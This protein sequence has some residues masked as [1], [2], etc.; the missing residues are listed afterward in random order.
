MSQKLHQLVKPFVGTSAGSL[1]VEKAISPSSSVDAQQVP[2][3]F[4]GTSVALQSNKST[5]C[6]PK[7]FA[8][9][10]GAGAADYKDGTPYRLTFMSLPVPGHPVAVRIDYT[11]GTGVAQT[12]TTTL[13][14]GSALL[15]QLLV[16]TS[17]SATTYRITAKSV[18]L[19]MDANA[20]TNNGTIYAVDVDNSYARTSE[21]LTSGVTGS[22]Y[23]S[24][25]WRGQTLPNMSP[26]SISAKSGSVAWRAV[27]GIYAVSRNEGE[28]VWARANNANV[29]SPANSG[30]AG[31]LTTAWEPALD[32][33]VPVI[34]VDNLNQNASV[35]C[36][37]IT[38]YEIQPEIGS[39]IQDVASVS[40]V[41]MAALAVYKSACA[42]F[43]AFYPADFNDWGTLW[44]GIKDF[45]AK[46]KPYIA[47]AANFIPGVGPLISTFIDGIPAQTKESRQAAMKQQRDKA[48]RA[49]LIEAAALKNAERVLAVGK[50]QGGPKRK[51][52]VPAGKA[53]RS[54]VVTN[55]RNRSSSTN[56]FR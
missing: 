23:A 17:T 18:T 11:G 42:N 14:E 29:Q 41:D 36:K 39:I 40:A 54:M 10:V 45:F 26:D 51:S 48:E 21:T 25:C 1:F 49:A 52:M 4:S 56:P 46:A 32:W 43:G 55:S 33:S 6:N 22:G 30:I 27:D 15:R 38:C 47:K 19:N 13:S 8:I 44:Q 28:F 3:E 34:V 31:P 7:L 50:V 35:I 24:F 37:A 16:T 12:V 20:T 53:I 2:D 5:S 9:A